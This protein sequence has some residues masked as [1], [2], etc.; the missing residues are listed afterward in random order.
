[1]VQARHLQSE[2]IDY[3]THSGIPTDLNIS[4]RQAYIIKMVVYDGTI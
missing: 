1:L 2:D 4:I 3:R